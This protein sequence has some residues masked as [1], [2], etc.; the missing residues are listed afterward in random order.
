MA[1]TQPAPG[2]HAHPTRKL[3]LRPPSRK[4]A[5]RLAEFLTGAVPAHP[6]TADHFGTLAFGLY[7]NDRFGDC[8]PTSV[9][10]SYG[11]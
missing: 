7:D 9:A 4:P 3:G 10:T 8:G 1:L 5:L 2:I 11:S 6:A